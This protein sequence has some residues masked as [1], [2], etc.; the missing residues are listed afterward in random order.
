MHLSATDLENLK[1]LK[2]EL[3]LEDKSSKLENLAAALL[4]RLLDV[5]IS[6]AKSG[7]QH[8][9]DAG[10]AGN[11]GRRFRLECKKYSDITRLSDRE[12]LGEIDHALARDEALEAWFLIATRSVPEQLAQDLRQK[13]ERIGVPVV[14][15]DWK[16]NELGSLAALCA[17]NPDLVAEQFSEKAA[18]L[19]RLLQPYADNALSMLRR[20]LQ[21]WQLGFDML[22]ARSH[23]LLD[24]IWHSPRESNAK[25][26]QDAAGGA[27]S[28]RVRRTGV[29]EA[30]SEWW[31]GPAETDAPATIIGWDGVG[32]TWAALDWLV[33]NKEALPVV[34]VV[35]SS[36]AAALSG[37]SETSVRR[38]L[39]DQLFELTGVRDSEHWL[40]RLDNL[41]KRPIEEG[42][43][44]TVFFDGLNQEPSVPWLSLLKV[45][46]GESFSGR[47]QVIVST[48]NH[49][50]ESK[51]SRLRSLIMP[52]VPIVVDIYD[53]APGG[54]L[55]QMLQ[56][57]GLERTDLHPDLIELASTPRLFK[58]VIKFRDRLVEAGQVTVH[59]LFWEYGRD[60]LGERAGRSFSEAEWRAWLQEVAQR[61]LA[62]IREFSVKSLSEMADRPDLSAG[63]AYAR[64]S[65]IVDGRFAVPGPSG[66]LQLTPTIVAHA[67]G[68][69]LLA[70]LDTME[71]ST[72]AALDAELMQ[73]LDPIAGFDQRLEILRAAVSIQVERGSSTES[74]LP[75]VLV[76][77]W[78][79]TQ[80]ITD[81]HRLELAGLAASLT[82]ALLDAVE[83]SRGQ[84][85]ASARLWAI[86][87]LRSI[88]RK[89]TAALD[90][91]V[92]RASH[93]L[94][95]VSRD[96]NP[97][98]ETNAELEARRSD[99][100]RNR[101]GMDASRRITVVG[102]DLELV[103][104]NDGGLQSTIPSIL[105]GFPLIRAQSVFEVTA[106][107]L[108]VRGRSEIWDGLRWLCLLN[109]TDPDETATALR[110]LSEEVRHRQPEPGVH[111]D[112]PARVVALLLWL[113]GQ[114]QDEDAATSINPAIG[115]PLSYER[116]YL[117]RPCRSLFPLERRH[118]KVALGDTEMPL[119]ARVQRTSELW[120]D[121]TF[122][123]PDAFVEEIRKAAAGIDVARLSRHGS[124]TIEDHH[125]ELLEPVL[126][127]C[128]PDQLADLIHRKMQSIATSPAES[129]YWSAIQVT[130]HFLLAGEAEAEAARVLRSS[131][132][133]SDDSQEFYAA[134]HLL[135]L[136]LQD[137]N[138]HAQIDALI[139]ADL[140]SFL[141]DLE[142]ILHTPTTD[143][144][145][146]LIARYADGSPKQQQDLLILLSIHPIEFS[147]DVWS[148]I[149]GFAKGEDR[150]L[151]SFAFYALTASGELRFGRTLATEG[152][153]WS[154]DA[155]LW[156]NHY[157]TEALIEAT[158]ALPFDQVVPRLAP[159]RVLEAAR[160]RGADPSEVR[161]AAQVFGHVLAAEKIDAPEPG[162]AL[163]VDRTEAKA[164]PFT[165]SVLPQ[166]IQEGSDPMAAL[167][168]AMDP[169]VQFKAQ[170]R[171][172]ETAVSRIREARRS[173]AS[174]YLTEVN[175]EDFGPVLQHASDMV[176]HWLEGSH[177]LT[178]DFRRRVALAESAFL[179]LCEALLAR[180]PS[181]GVQLWRA[182]HSFMSTRYIG[183]ADVND[184]LHMVFRVPESEAIAELRK[185]L[186]ELDLCHTDRALLDIAIAAS[187]NGESNW[188]REMV[189]AD[190]SSNLVWKRKRGTVLAG[191]KANNSLPVEGAWPE[192]EIR[193]GYAALEQRSARF[194]W[195]EACARYWWQA[196]LKA[197]ES[198]EAYASWV[199][200]LRSA[201]HRAW[202]WMHQDVEAANNTSEFFELK[203][204]HVQ[205]N[206]SKLKRAMQKRTEKLQENLFDRKIVAGVGP[207]VKEY[208]SVSC[209]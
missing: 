76:T 154:P 180:D 26:G 167:K 46:Q 207:W 50:F 208:D 140:R 121:P 39:A 78:L 195:V 199:L 15:L 118:A 58:L 169:E 57:E 83:H 13:G 186:I 172:V 102:V 38:F 32:K 63:E 110:E 163:V 178:A 29:H 187:Y 155:P 141:N 7:F 95:I 205:L 158:R 105:E 65:D 183:A 84:S 175:A 86:N 128:A 48:R 197:S 148:W 30:L 59:R 2:R 145:D 85:Q 196:Y 20:D 137:L 36:A 64:L 104:R 107:A 130:D 71:G 109:E 125:F 16:D 72:F 161:L 43:V 164:S 111:P 147:N 61:H 157:G 97:R 35:P 194:R 6:V 185:E 198:A 135:M 96:V 123:P 89:D 22:R 189:E 184:L 12:L 138:A 44:L 70:H 106:V 62:G 19:A 14:I 90:I 151:R 200:F 193:T 119:L 87:A 179:A 120:F 160:R 114:E 93:W 176:E 103:D 49:H 79:Q 162:S 201:D 82:G 10:P 113:S 53:A 203:L 149:E 77:A 67:L 17:S 171:A 99:L 101:I 8:G 139:R 66:N 182:L 23:E 52:G 170:R 100:L 173:G 134:S 34:L 117:P 166:S 11:Q 191:F 31:R 98:G 60:T 108:A 168:A 159:W 150:E 27:Q 28:S 136:E 112:L 45:L 156:V 116:D 144:A 146:A 206:R 126:A 4:G 18:I 177:E 1:N 153:S 33:D 40:R 37:A 56:F 47:V 54:E 51:L 75:G 9:G 132:T 115:H 69:A 80:N 124:H 190:Q 122:E 42:P 24:K 143:D 74:A 73:W 127:R 188:L 181:R 91:I 174:L 41:L 94:S 142:E 55:D 129:R 3:Q 68:A 202:I 81:C 88:P 204:S 165:F 209:S 21:S 192:G 133:E 92:E 5:P 25:F 152:W 131:A